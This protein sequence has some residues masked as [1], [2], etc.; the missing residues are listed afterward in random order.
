MISN[1]LSR[2]MTR[3]ALGLGLG[4]FAGCLEDPELKTCAELPFGSE[5]CPPDP[6][7]TYCGEMTVLCPGTF[8][9]EDACFLRCAI[10][11][12]NGVVRAGEVGDTSGDTLGC[13]LTQASNGVCEQAGLQGSMVCIDASCDEY[14]SQMLGSGCSDAYP[15]LANCMATCSMFPTGTG[16]QVDENS[17]GCRFRYLQDALI[18][19]SPANCNAA[20]PSGG[21]VCGDPCDVYCDFLGASC[22]GSDAVYASRTECKNTCSLFDLGSFDDWDFSTEADSLQCR[23]YHAGPPAAAAPTTH[24]PHTAVYNPMHCGVPSGGATA[25]GWQCETYCDMI[26]RNCSG[27]YPTL[28]ACRVDC[29]TFPEVLAA[30]D[31]VPNIY[32]V[33]STVCPTRGN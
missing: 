16:G 9:S 30:G 10:E 17:L 2:V 22:T 25:V 15:S 14:C 27:L 28:G 8:I 7:R 5:G 21:G 32:P 4:L 23:I 29:L 13:R 20:S 33:T 31:G 24:C 26:Q 18:E 12:I 1:D 3:V 6:C 11:P 19:A